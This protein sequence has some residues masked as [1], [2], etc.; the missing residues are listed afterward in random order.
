MQGAKTAFS[1]PLLVWGIPVVVG[2]FL[3][4]LW[5]LFLLVKIEPNTASFLPP[6]LILINVI[7]VAELFVFQRGFSK[8]AATMVAVPLAVALVINAYSHFLS[9]GTDNFFRMPPGEFRLSYQISAILLVML[10][11]LGCWIG[12]RMFGNATGKS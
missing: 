1:R 9:S 3:I 4:V 11:V 2:H 7:P 12:Y 6:L 10:G 5:H 8:L